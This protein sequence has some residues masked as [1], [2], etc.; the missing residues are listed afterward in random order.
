M[1]SR[2]VDVDIDRIARLMVQKNVNP[3][4]YIDRY[5]ESMQGLEAPPQLILEGWLGNFFKRIGNAWKSFWKDPNSPEA[6]SEKLDAA[7]QALEDL[8]ATVKQNQGAEATVLPTILKGLEQSLTI[9]NQIEPQIKQLSGRITAFQKSGAGPTGAAFADDPMHQLPQ[10]LNQKWQKL[11]AARDALVK[12]PDSQHK[13]DALVQNDN[14]FIQ[15]KH[16]LEELYQ[17]LNPNDPDPQKQEYKKKLENWLRRIDTDSTFNEIEALLDV[18]RRRTSSGQLVKRPNGYMDLLNFWQQISQ[19][20]H[21]PN[22][23][24]DQIIA[25]YGKLPPAHP[26]KKFV[27]DEMKKSPNIGQD[28]NALFYKYAYN[29]I[30]KFPHHLAR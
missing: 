12:Q 6:A 13:A 17:N 29:W 27:Q 25:W 24:R 18:A 26:L 2:R 20:V 30:T 5:L 7:K 8:V 15:F 3:R 19:T 14:E 28:E 22:Q 9:L 16:E 1:G 10:D 11:M 23:Q 21:D 4:W